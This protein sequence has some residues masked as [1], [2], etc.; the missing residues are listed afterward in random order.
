MNPDMIDLSISSAPFIRDKRK[1]FHIMLDVLIALTP[2]TI[3]SFVIF[4]FRHPF[5]II[6]T[7]VLSSIIAEYLGDIVF[8]K[9]PSIFDLSS[10]VTGLLL[11]LVMPP[12]SPYW[13]VAV[14]AFVG[15][16]L[17][18]VIFGGIGSNPF[19]PALVG[20]AVLMVS[21]PTF[22]TQWIKP[23]FL[24]TVAGATPIDSITTATPL[25][26]Y[27]LQGY[28]KLIADFGTKSNLYKALFL[29]NVG[30]SLGETSA[31]LIL[32]GGIYLLVRKV[33]DW[34]IPTSYIVTVFVFSWIFGRDPLFSI[35]AG[36]LFLGAFFMATDYSSS[37][38]TPKGKIVYGVFIGLMTVIIRQYSAYPEG[39]MF[40]IL[41]GNAFVPFF[42]KIVPHV[43]G[44][45]NK[46][47]VKQ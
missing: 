19:N 39:V 21:W 46:K 10:G 16:W 1:T 22:M 13:L 30:G 41:L 25:G 11:A 8:K 47:E 4:G 20:R 35:L 12:S 18:K 29:G 43:Y 36:G 23:K 5:G 6:L 31:L 42:D 9:K 45:F 37:P 24:M 15:I 40:S 33:I 27:K 3:G 26:V 14:G 32:I 7:A 44:V 34:R 38:I 28:A 2:V 17:G